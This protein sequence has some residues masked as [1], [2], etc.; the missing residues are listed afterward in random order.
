[1]TYSESLDVLW[2]VVSELHTLL[3]LG[4]EIDSALKRKSEVQ[5]DISLL[6]D[7]LNSLESVE[8]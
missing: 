6:L 1:M 7:R 3:S 2:D 4:L 5:R 8:V